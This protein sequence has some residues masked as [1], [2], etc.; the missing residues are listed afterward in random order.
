MLLLHHVTHAAL[1]CGG[2]ERDRL[3]HLEA[4]VPG[5]NP[6]TLAP[7]GRSRYIGLHTTSHRRAR[8]SSSTVHELSHPTISTLQPSSHLPGHGQRHPPDGSSNSPSPHLSRINTNLPAPPGLLLPKALAV[9]QGFGERGAQTQETPL[10]STRHTACHPSTYPTSQGQ[11]KSRKK[12][13]TNC[14]DESGPS[15]DGLELLQLCK[16]RRRRAA[17]QLCLYFLTAIILLGD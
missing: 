2:C 12:E 16:S 6:H 9:W 11:K 14:K 7:R 1:L 5:G 15:P 3:Q 4:Q 17:R 13:K 10:R 8:L